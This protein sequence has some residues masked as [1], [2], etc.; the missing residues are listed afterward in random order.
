MSRRLIL[1]SYLAAGG[2]YE[3]AWRHPSTDTASMHGI[4][5]AI[6]AARR[7]EVAGI[8]AVMFGDS[9]MLYPSTERGGYYGVIPHDPI[10][11]MTAVAM[12]TSTIGLVATA[13]TTYSEPYNLARGLA[14]LDHVS[15]GRAAWNVVT[16]SNAQAAANFGAEPH[17]EHA[18]RYERAAEF[19]EVVRA[20]WRS[21]D[22]D[23]ILADQASGQFLRAGSVRPINYNGKHFCVAGPLNTPRTPQTEPVLV[24]AGASQRGV[25]FGAGF[26]EL[27]FT[28][29]QN[30][31]GAKQF[32]EAVKT[33]AI[34]QGRN[35][36][37][38]RVLPGVIPIIADTE[39]AANDLVNSLQGHTDPATGLAALKSQLGLDLTEDQLDEPFPVLDVDRVGGAQ[40]RAREVNDMV[41]EGNLPLRQLLARLAGRGHRIFVGTPAQFADQAQAWF[42]GGA[43]DG[44]TLLPPFHPAG[45]DVFLD[46]VMP[47]LRRRGLVRAPES[48]K[49]LRE[50]LRA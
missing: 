12:H 2:H 38:V 24:Q 10:V 43:C 9:P 29:Q 34:A 8:D 19:L 27:I 42:L 6:E 25:D 17:T 5:W 39:A 22:E 31:G 48:G 40:S 26:A 21:W 1:T 35:P 3:A 46:E 20:L 45:F 7:A 41:R 11:A 23:A 14:S 30:I 50:R 32:Y 18:V 28:A 47:E 49:T 15:D 33:S 16:T 36:E 4:G 44:F 13:S 37:D